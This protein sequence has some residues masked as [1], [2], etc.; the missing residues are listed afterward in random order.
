MREDSVVTLLGGP[1]TFGGRSL[2]SI[3]LDAEIRRGFKTRVI[4]NFKSHTGL[5]NA[6]LARM[7]LVSARTIDRL[8]SSG[9]LKPATSDRLY[10][11]ARIFA[12]AESVL[13]DRDQARQ[14][15][16]A[17]QHGLGER[18]PLEL[19]ETGPGAR[20]VENE[21]LRIEHGFVA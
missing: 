18:V 12:L 3:E 4:S 5:S 15:L 20:A 19:I 14:W 9:R 11:A 2:E 17:P 16:T 8:E 10:R 6:S 13:E 21:L 1:R 7:L